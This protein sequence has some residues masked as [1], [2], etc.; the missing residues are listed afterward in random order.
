MKAAPLKF[1]MPDWPVPAR[2]RVCTTLRGG[3]VSVGA[4][5]SLNL[6]EHVGDRAEHVA[7]N[8]RRLRATLDLPGEP[9]WLAQVHGT[10]VARGDGRAGSPADAA[11]ASAPG[12]VCAVLTAD[13]LPVVLA[14]RDAT[15]VAVAHA[16]WRGLAAGVLEATLAALGLPPSRLV[17]WLGPAI[18][19]PAFEV[20]EEVRAAFVARTPCY[21]SA[22]AGNARG[23][24]QADL[25]ALA[26]ITLAQA[27]VASVHGGSWC[28]AGDPARFF[29]YRRDG[30]TGR[31]ATLAWLA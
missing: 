12:E 31:M 5:A 26:R 28:T 11:V 2:V 29:S 13:C 17:A 10:A 4:F 9:L 3:G 16:G 21:A 6:A 18:S 22:F 20:G 23:R 7:E 19:Q 15:R 24:F 8:R 25:L 30:T 14:D 1:L 27:G